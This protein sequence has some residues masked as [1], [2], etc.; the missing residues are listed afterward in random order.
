MYAVRTL[1]SEN[2]F[3]GLSDSSRFLLN[4]ETM[5]VN[6]TKMQC[7]NVALILASELDYKSTFFRQKWA[8]SLVWSWGGVI[9]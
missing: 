8:R 1:Q 9:L 5:D 2:P 3:P 4:V 6:L 7:V